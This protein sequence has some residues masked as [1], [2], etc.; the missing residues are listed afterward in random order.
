VNGLS[1][2]AATDKGFKQA[3]T[4]ILDSNLTTI[5]VAIFLYSFGSGVV[6]GFAV[7]LIIGISTSMFSA[8]TLTKLMMATWLNYTRPKKIVL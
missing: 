3:F 4:T 1:P 5:I 2:I 8:I 7:T 6:K